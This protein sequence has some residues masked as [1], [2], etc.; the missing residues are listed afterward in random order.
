MR[1][2]DARQAFM[3]SQTQMKR[4][5]KVL[6]RSS[7][8]GLTTSSSS[9][10]GSTARKT[11][12]LKPKSMSASQTE[13]QRSSTLSA[14]RVSTHPPAPSRASRRPSPLHPSSTAPPEA[15]RPCPNPSCP[16]R[17]RGGCRRRRC[18]AGA[19]GSASRSS[20]FYNDGGRTRMLVN[21]GAMRRNCG[22][23][24]SKCHGSR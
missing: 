17:H 22:I 7:I 4:V 21:E 13:G 8:V 9:T 20:A 18:S 11:V 12:A 15:C 2:T 24:W 23:E 14:S 10:N 16:T 5:R 6:L 3:K 1:G 19:S